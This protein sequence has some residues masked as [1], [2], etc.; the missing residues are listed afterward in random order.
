MTMP[1][2][3]RDVEA[4][5]IKKGFQR[6]ESKDAYFH[7]WVD[8][9]KTSLWTKI[10]QGEKEIHDGLVA[11]MARQ[12]R[13]KTRQFGEL[14]DCPLSQTEYEGILRDAGHID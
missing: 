12:V 8:G 10:S 14:I 11:M 6:R 1:R 7:F 13:L 2:K 4:A 5:L 9:K 3:V